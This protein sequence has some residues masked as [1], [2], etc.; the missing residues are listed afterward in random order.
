MEWWMY[1]DEY[2]RVKGKI[3]IEQWIYSDEYHRVQGEIFIEQWI[4]SDEYK[5]PQN[6][7]LSYILPHFHSQLKI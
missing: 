1:S 6:W 4:C 5:I 7:Q 2:H 3:F